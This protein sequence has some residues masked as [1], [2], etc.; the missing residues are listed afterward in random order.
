MGYGS[1]GLGYD[2]VRSTDHEWGPRLLLFVD[3]QAYADVTAQVQEALSQRLHRVF[4]GYSTHF[5]GRMLRASRCARCAS[6]AQ[7]S[8][9]WTCI[10]PASSVSIALGLILAVV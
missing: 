6:L 1:D 5:G 9:G 4:Y 10:R 8:T 2:T 3:E 7:R